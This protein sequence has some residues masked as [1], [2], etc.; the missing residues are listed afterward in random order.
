MRSFCLAFTLLTSSLLA[1]EAPFLSSKDPNLGGS[2]VRLDADGRATS[3]GPV[4]IDPGAIGGDLP[5][6]YQ[7]YRNGELIPSATSQTL[8][9]PVVKRQHAG[10]YSLRVSNPFGRVESGAYSLV[11]VGAHVT[12][13]RRVSGTEP[14]VLSVPNVWGPATFR[15]VVTDG[16]EDDEIT[17]TMGHGPMARLRLAGYRA[18]NHNFTALVS[19]DAPGFVSDFMHAVDFRLDVDL[20]PVLS[21]SMESFYDF[22]VG[23]PVDLHLPF[24][25]TEDDPTAPPLP[26]LQLEPL[27]P[28]LKA[29]QVLEE[30]GRGSWRLVGRPTRPGFYRTL[31]TATTAGGVLKR[32]VFFIVRAMNHQL[33]E[34]GNTAGWPTPPGVYEGSLLSVPFGLPSGIARVHVTSQ[35]VATCVI[36]LGAKTYRVVAR[37]S[38]EGLFTAEMVTP[39]GSRNVELRFIGYQMTLDLEGSPDSYQ[40]YLTASSWELSSFP[41]SRL[42]T[43]YSLSKGRGRDGDDHQILS[44]L[45]VKANAQATFATRLPDGSVATASGGLDNGGQL[46]FHQRV[47]RAGWLSGYIG[48]EMGSQSFVHY[49]S[50]FGTFQWTRPADARVKQERR[51][52]FDVM[53][54]SRYRGARKDENLLGYEERVDNADLEPILPLVSQTALPEHLTIAKGGAATVSGENPSAFTL[55]V[56][57]KTGVA[58]GSFTLIDAGKSRVVS[59]QGLVIGAHDSRAP[60]NVYLMGTTSHLPAEAETEGTLR[61]VLLKVRPTR[62][63]APADRIA[64][65]AS[66]ADQ[67]G[68]VDAEASADNPIELT[69]LEGLTLTLRTDAKLRAG[70]RFHWKISLDEGR[71]FEEI[72]PGDNVS[73][74][75][76]RR[77]VVHRMSA[78]AQPVVFAAFAATGDERLV[79]Q[80][81]VTVINVPNYSTFTYWQSSPFEV[82]VDEEQ[83]LPLEPAQYQVVVRGMPRGLM[84]R[85]RTF[86]DSDGVK[87]TRWAIV[88]RPVK[89]GIFPVR[90]TVWNDAGHF[91]TPA[92]IQ[93]APMHPL[94]G[95]RYHGLIEGSVSGS[96]FGGGAISLALTPLGD[97]TGTLTTQAGKRPIIGSFRSRRENPDNIPERY[98]SLRLPTAQD[99]QGP[100]LD[101]SIDPS[102]AAI[103]G[104]LEGERNADGERAK[105]SLY[106]QPEKSIPARRLHCLATDGQ[107]DV[108]R[109]LAVYRSYGGGAAQLVVRLGRGVVTMSGFTTGTFNE[110][111]FSSLFFQV[112]RPGHEFLQASLYDAAFAELFVMARDPAVVDSESV[113]HYGM[114][115]SAWY[116]ML[117]RSILLDVPNVFPNLRINDVP[118]D[119]LPGQS[120]YSGLPANPED[121]TLLPSSLSLNRS[122]G[123]FTANSETPVQQR[124]FGLVFPDLDRAVGIDWSLPAEASDEPRVL[125]I[126]PY[127]QQ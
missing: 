68:S 46:S 75:G 66:A 104:S 90:F 17:R 70:E 88:G 114:N 113:T 18:K 4:I 21:Q 15:W 29:R 62:V 28:G 2:M 82:G 79:A 27:P 49:S 127:D 100:L 115:I 20:P 95:Q 54:S 122:T 80:Y 77:L 52:T 7:W 91:T 103:A 105:A 5:L 36:K 67:E 117:P 87:Q 111:Y 3:H 86:T 51:V 94:A 58:R 33:G 44:Q 98:A 40:A 96:L 30:D 93:V 39:E 97:F 99:P 11:V 60:A 73:G 72:E 92:Y 120:G 81:R 10:R 59:L 107:A 16:F 23:A 76:T 61:T 74:V 84:L 118:F 64:A 109:G 123:V 50:A 1:G 126:R 13:S 41:R 48:V 35:G 9:I 26:R 121:T 112:V 53:E 25:T 8:A 102:S 119:F 42:G 34:P 65:S 32:D 78:L 24:A 6:R 38:S 37:M 110:P 89:A 101:I 124:Y 19:V 83:L 108:P 45:H 71:S 22:S 106:L 47:G 57:P 125:D 116:P 69:V 43:Y 55:Q 31:I 12:V 63:T 85:P 14:S 56:N